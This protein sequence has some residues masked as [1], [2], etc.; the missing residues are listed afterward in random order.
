MARGIRLAGSDAQ[1]CYSLA[2]GP[3]SLGKEPA[4]YSKTYIFLC[5]ILFMQSLE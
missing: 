1:L 5:F 3:S 2:V 4:G